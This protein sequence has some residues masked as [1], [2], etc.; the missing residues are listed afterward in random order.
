[1]AA[2]AMAVSQVE[3]LKNPCRVTTWNSFVASQPP[4]SAPPMPITQVMMRLC[5]LLPGIST[6]AIRPAPR[7]RTIHAMMPTT[8]LLCCDELMAGLVPDR[9]R[10]VWP[11]RGF[12]IPC[13]LA[14]HLSVKPE[15]SAA[16]RARNRKR[17]HPDRLLANLLGA[18]GPRLEHIVGMRAVATHWDK[19]P[20]VS[21]KSC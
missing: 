9:G 7:P 13:R 18:D 21:E 10:G 5:D 6:L 3:R 4:S 12:A 19:L 16:E 8:G 17:H 2:P 1:M 14:C 15:N 20:R 11:R